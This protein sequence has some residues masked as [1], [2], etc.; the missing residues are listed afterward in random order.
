MNG[1]TDMADRRLAILFVTWFFPPFDTMGA[2]RLGKMAKH[3]LARGHDVRV[4]CAEGLPY[5]RSVP[6]E[7]PDERIYRAGWIDVNGFPKRV[8]RVRR[9]IQGG[10][11]APA[12]AAAAP[13]AAAPASAP[14]SAD[15]SPLRRLRDVYLN[16][17]NLPDPQ[18]G[19]YPGALR[20]GRR[21]LAGWRPDLVFASAPPPT[22]LL[23][24]RRLAG[25]AGVPWVAEYRDRWTEDPYFP[26]PRWRQWLDR[27]MEDRVLGSA[28][29]IVT[30]SEPWAA[31]YVARWGKPVSVVYNGFDPDDF[32]AEY[33]RRPNDPA[34]LDIVYTGVLYGDR[35]DPSPLFAALA[36]MGEEAKAVQVHFYGAEPDVLAAKVARHGVAGSVQIHGRVPYREAIRVQMEADVLLLMQWTDPKEAGNSPGKLFEYIGARRPV[37]GLGLDDGVPARILRARNAGVMVNDPAAIAA[38]LRRWLAEK[39]RLGAIPLL[40]MTAR[41]GLS[42]TDQYAALEATLAALVAARR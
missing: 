31:D 6:V 15:G 40:P 34:V 32:P 25:I 33:D 1:A 27:T 39:R 38:Q 41:D 14:S 7:I 35:R 13:V 10:G 42:R 22:A 3:F 36:L 29:A 20:A 4:V 17:T 28:A 11:R 2:L 8:Q 9:L 18:I 19:W 21:A 23:I 26:P 5:G 24:G 16:L 37:L 12:T 30:V